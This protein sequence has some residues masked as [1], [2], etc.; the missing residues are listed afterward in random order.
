[1]KYKIFRIK[2]VDYQFIHYYKYQNADKI[3]KY[4]NKNTI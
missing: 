1:M 4:C 2:F 3:N